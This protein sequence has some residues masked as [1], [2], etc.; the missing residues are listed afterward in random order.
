MILTVPQDAKWVNQYAYDIRV[1]GRR[2]RV[3]IKRLRP[4]A[5]ASNSLLRD[6]AVSMRLFIR[7]RLR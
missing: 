3:Y 4:I 1:R 5:Y 7:R 2:R 6:S